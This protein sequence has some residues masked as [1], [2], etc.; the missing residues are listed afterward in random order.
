MRTFAR[1]IVRNAVFVSIVGTLLGVVG[2]YYSIQL[3]KNLR[4]DIEELLPTTAR[5]VVD[6]NEVA[7]R[8][9]SIDNLAVLVFSKARIR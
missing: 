9:E 6:L 5:S 1:F 2:A 8:L 4:T 7:S 3:Y